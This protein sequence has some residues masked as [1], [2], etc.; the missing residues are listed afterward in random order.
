MSI[1]PHIADMSLPLE[2]EQS[3]F[4]DGCDA[5]FNERIPLWHISCYCHSLGY[6]IAIFYTRLTIFRKHCCA[7]PCDNVH[8]IR[9]HD[10]RTAI[11]GTHLP[12]TKTRTPSRSTNPT[13]TPSFPS[14][15][16]R[17][18]SKHTSQHHSQHSWAKYT[19]KR[20]RPSNSRRLPYSNRN[21]GPSCPSSATSASTSRRAMGAGY[22]FR[23]LH[24]HKILLRLCPFLVH[25]DILGFNA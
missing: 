19:P 11:F 9:T 6:G 3:L 15:R 20:D 1:P 8:G 7:F 24:H 23:I 14:S 2:R 18:T 22:A 10:V 5:G 17:N 4:L 12:S 13:T 25:F 21:T 16:K